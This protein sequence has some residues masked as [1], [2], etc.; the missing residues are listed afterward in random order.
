M[1][2]FEIWHFMKYEIEKILRK[3]QKKNNEIFFYL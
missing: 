1:F 2:K 3:V